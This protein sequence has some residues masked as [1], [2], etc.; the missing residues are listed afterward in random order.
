MTPEQTWLA[1]SFEE[2]QFLVQ[3]LEAGFVVHSLGETPVLIHR[4][5]VRK[6]EGYGPIG[7]SHGPIAGDISQYIEERLNKSQACYELRRQG[8]KWTEVAEKAS[9]LSSNAVTLAKNYA[10]SN[11]LPWPIAL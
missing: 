6:L 2:P 9:V 5:D 3:C 11:G 8:F 7:G 4:K 1:E 10:A